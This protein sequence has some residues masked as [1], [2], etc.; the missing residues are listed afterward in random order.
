MVT[1]RSMQHH[2]LSTQKWDVEKRNGITEYNRGYPDV[3]AS[4]ILG[5]HSRWV[6]VPPSPFWSN[7]IWLTPPQ[8]V[9]AKPTSFLSAIT[10]SISYVFISFNSRPLLSFP[11]QH[12]LI[13]HVQLGSRHPRL[14]Q[15]FPH[16]NHQLRKNIR[17]RPKC[18]L[19][20]HKRFPSH[21]PRYP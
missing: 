18:I 6:S 5:L 21:Q 2:I 1:S 19:S 14:S 4:T 17:H 11:F 12:P 10:L 7:R 16:P 8:N 20:N 13:S 15:R 3:Y 9:A